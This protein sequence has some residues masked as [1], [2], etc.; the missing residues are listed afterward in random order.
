MAMCSGLHGGPS[1]NMSM[2]YDSM[3]V[4]FFWK[5]VFAYIIKDLETR[6]SWVIWAL[7]QM[8]SVLMTHRETKT[9]REGR[10]KMEAE[11]GGM[12]PQAKKCLEPPGAGRGKDFSLEPSKAVWH[13]G[14][15][16]FGPPELP[17]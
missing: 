11:T 6:A 7:N 17:E 2:S 10:V 16:D 12:Q 15:L 4:K 5:R 9:E 3:N 13:G 8:T 1:K 14:H